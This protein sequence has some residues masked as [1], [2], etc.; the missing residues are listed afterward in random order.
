MA[1]ATPF[2]TGLGEPMGMA[3]SNNFS[4]RH[5]DSDIFIADYQTGEILR[6]GQ[7]GKAQKPLATGLKGPTMIVKTATDVYVSER[8]ASRVLRF[9][10]TDLGYV[11]PPD[12]VGDV[13]Q[14]LGLTFRA[15]RR[16]PEPP[17]DRPSEWNMHVEEIMVTSPATSQIYSF[18]YSYGPEKSTWKPIYK[19]PKV[20]GDSYIVFDG[21]VIFMTDSINGEVLMVS[22]EGRAAP[23]ASGIAKPSGIAMGRDGFLYVAN[24]GEGGQ[25]IRLNAEGEKTVVAEKLGRPCGMLFLNSKIVFVSSRDGNIWKVTLP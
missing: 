6:Y 17:G 2:I 24:E 7:N 1:T 23:F 25:L 4:D 13:S 15:T 21:S 12:L 8:N 16:H 19:S 11:F 9:E 3:F 14:P 22:P 10:S 20:S 18:R 5:P